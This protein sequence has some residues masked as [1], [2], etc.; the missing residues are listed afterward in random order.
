MPVAVHHQIETS[1][2]GFPGVNNT[3][4]KSKR[5]MWKGLAAKEESISAKNAVVREL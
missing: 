3:R 2:R 5:F 4:R 1:T